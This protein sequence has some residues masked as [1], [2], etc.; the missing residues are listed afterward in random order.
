LPLSEFGIFGDDGHAK[1][2]ELF[3]DASFARQSDG[4]GYDPE[5]CETV[6]VEF[7]NERTFNALTRHGGHIR[8]MAGDIRHLVAPARQF[9]AELRIWVSE[10]RNQLICGYLQR[11]RNAGPKCAL[12]ILLDYPAWNVSAD[13]QSTL[14]IRLTVALDAFGQDANYRNVQVS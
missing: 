13:V 4:G 6:F 8:A 5:D 10:R 11:R 3:V 9:A 14:V 2:A 7:F 12:Q 1:L